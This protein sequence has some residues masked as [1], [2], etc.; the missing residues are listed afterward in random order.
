MAKKKIKKK[1]T[2]E[3]KEEI[4]MEGELPKKSVIEHEERQL[5]WFF[6]IVGI[7][8][9]IVLVSYFGAES[10]KA[11][12]FGGVDWRV[13]EYAEPL[14]IIYHG[15]FMAL[16]GAN[17]EFNIFLRN[18]PRT[19]DVF[20]EGNFIDFNYGGIISWSDEIEACR[21]EVSRAM[22][23]VGAFI[24]TGIGVG[25]LETA[26][27]N[28]EVSDI[29]DRKYVDCS[30]DLNKTVVVVQKGES[31]VIQDSD[32]SHCYVI[33]VAD[34]NDVAPMEKFITKTISD[35]MALR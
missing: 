19:N 29:S 35:A 22:A 13:E 8:F 11:F 4:E 14:G 12:E 24:I 32:N 20:T 9:A 26:T 7:V 5:V 23:D 28:P 25:K 2:E 1:L 10:V 30:S 3:E 18:D 6:V 27:T 16:N 17:M 34:C 21:G 15:Q 33:N 31:S